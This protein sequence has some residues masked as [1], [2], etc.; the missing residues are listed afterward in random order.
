MARSAARILIVDDDRLILDSLG[1]MLAQDGYAVE[2]AASMKDALA[3]LEQ[4]P[5]ELVLSDINMPGGDGFE[6]LTA[7]RQRWPATVAVMMTAYGTIDSAVEAI[8]LGAYDYLTKPIMDDE[9][10]L[11]IERALAQQHILHENRQLKQ[12]LQQRFGLE[13]LIG[14]DY[15][16]LKVFELIETVAGSSVTVLIQGPSGTGKSLTARVIH[17]LSERAAGPF[18]EVAVGA[19]P[20]T[21]IES[22][23]FGHVR[24]AFTGAVANKTGKFKAANGGTIFLDEIGT[25]SPA[26]QVKL[27]RV[28]QERQFEPVGSN[29]TE[30]VDVRVV[31]AT[32]VNLE[33]EVRAGRF[34]EDLFYRINVITLD[35]PP[36][37]ERISDIPLLAEC[38]LRRS[39]GDH[40]RQ[41]KGFTIEALTALQA[42]A[43][44]G[45]VRELANVVERCA[46][47][48]RGEHVGLSDLPP[49]IAE[50]A[51]EPAAS[52]HLGHVRPLREALEEPERRI[53]EAAL[54][55]HGWSRNRTAAALDI[56]RTTLY[57]KMK[58]YDL[59]RPTVELA[60]RGL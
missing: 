3:L 37:C 44:P 34:R 38:F 33:S 52:A 24:G 29:R 18:I 25:A 59:L 19:I 48:C 30:S 57:K 4:M 12:E 5:F 16:M 15:R 46:I 31:C 49:K 10:R 1:E 23:L 41:V 27:L 20:E 40:G 35:L 17:R 13:A 42:Y 53:I 8:R 55:A 60:A 47:L 26:L 43:W 32:N 11:V 45:N 51:A 58:R 6:L 7:I 50:A 9:L 21:L 2:R 22:E 39:R 36:L 28:L 14:H 54:R 56:D